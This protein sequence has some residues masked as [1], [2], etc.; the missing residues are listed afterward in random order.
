MVL[1]TSGVMRPPR[2]KLPPSLRH[3]CP[4]Q[5]N[6]STGFSRGKGNS[7]LHVSEASAPPLDYLSQ[8]SSF[9]SAKW[10]HG[11]R[12]DVLRGP[13]FNIRGMG[14][15]FLSWTNYLYCLLSTE[16]YTLTACLEKLIHFRSI[17]KIT[18]YFNFQLFSEVVKYCTLYSL[19]ECALH[20]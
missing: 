8:S 18:I 19:I 1:P 17:G 10:Q 11:T 20:I 5:C 9:Q 3:T 6:V 16:H 2:V 4:F 7:R 15:E 14:Q 13:P 12:N